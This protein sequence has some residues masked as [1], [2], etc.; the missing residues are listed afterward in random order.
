MTRYR[1]ITNRYGGYFAQEKGWFF[2]HTL[3]HPTEMV[4]DMEG[5]YVPIRLN[6]STKEDA[7]KRIRERIAERK[8]AAREKQKT[9]IQIQKAGRV[10]HEI[11]SFYDEV[12]IS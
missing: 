3:C 7:I 2:W 11:T 6:F 5:G 12:N 1:V 9:N 10:V 8:L 4:S